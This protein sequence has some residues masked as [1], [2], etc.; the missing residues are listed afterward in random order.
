MPGVVGHTSA[1]VCFVPVLLHKLR[2]VGR[3]DAVPLAGCLGRPGSAIT[4]GPVLQVITGR[5]GELRGRGS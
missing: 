1:V 3:E 2:L 5:N 4:H